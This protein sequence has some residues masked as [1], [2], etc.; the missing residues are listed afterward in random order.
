MASL[1][2]LYTRSLATHPLRTRMVASA[3]LFTVADV[4]S[5]QAIERRGR[6]HD[7]V[8]TMRLAFYGG[9]IFAPL[10]N[11]WLGVLEKVV[12]PGHKVATVA[13]K[14]VLDVGCWGPTIIAVFWSMTG[15][16]EMQSLEEVKERV[17]NA[18]FPALQK[19]VMVFGPSQVINFTFVPV[20]HRM[21]FTQLVGLGW[22]VFLSY[23]SGRLQAEKE[24]LTRHSEIKERD[25][26][27]LQQ[28]GI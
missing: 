2:R 18:Y 13:L 9:F 8:R 15:F 16:L 21:L 22:N 5:Q 26:L 14:V 17:R 1:W 12:I 3:S 27:V 20:P 4:V 11:T 28:I 24:P 23:S 6:L 10:V 25:G 19:S 7:P